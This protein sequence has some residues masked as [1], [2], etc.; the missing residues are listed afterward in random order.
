MHTVNDFEN[1]EPVTYVP[2]HAN[3]DCSH[4]DCERGF[5]TSS[6]EKFV[7]VRFNGCTSQACDP[8]NLVKG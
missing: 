4:K 8:A 1:G 2:N 3:G 6:N 5:V 7:F